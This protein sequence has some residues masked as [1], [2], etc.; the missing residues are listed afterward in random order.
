[1]DGA[2]TG[3]VTTGFDAAAV[4]EHAR[5]S[6]IVTDLSGVIADC[7]RQ[8]EVLYGR[9]RDELIGADAA[10]YVVDPLDRELTTA[11]AEELLTGETWSG[12][13]QVRRADGALVVVEAIASAIFDHG[14][15]FRGVVSV[16]LDITERRRAERHAS[17]ARV[18]L[19]VLA[20]VGQ[21]LAVELDLD[22]RLQSVA[23]VLLSD[24]ADLCAL[25]LLSPDGRLRLV[26]TAHVDPV[27]DD[28]FR[29]AADEPATPPPGSPIQRAIVGREPVLAHG[30]EAEQVCVALLA[31]ARPVEREILRCESAICLPLFGLDGRHGVLCLGRRAS[32]DPYTA[33]DVVAG[34]E[35][36]RRVDLAIDHAQRFE[37]QRNAAEVLQRSLLPARLPDVPFATI[38]WR[39]VPGSS[40][41]TI[42]GDWFDAIL[43]PD[44]RLVLAIGD[45]AGHGLRAAVAM[46]RARHCLEFCVFEGLSPGV[47]LER[48]SHFL[49]GT[50]EA[51]LVTAAVAILDARAG[52]LTLA[53][54]GHPPILVRDP[55]GTSSYVQ[56]V[57]GPPLAVIPEPSF[58]E[59]TIPLEQGATIVLYTDGLVERRG[60]AIT[61][62]FERLAA[63]MDDVPGGPGVADHLLRRLAS[64]DDTDDD[65]AVLVVTFDG[66]R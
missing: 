37:Q 59:T 48:M 9:P 64:A 20:R 35:L 7:N 49:Y 3:A 33:E 4:L 26:A 25:W 31:D 65:V 18:R 15:E 54:A 28:A 39:Y 16:A 13:F 23:R 11:I 41:L 50:L 22:E 57:N 47:M 46:G 10:Q 6:V 51:D 44:D 30:A 58:D 63:V 66:G 17:D 8:A 19:E 40:D 12:E 29:R 2:T 21:L 24:F 36:A 38:E 14:G 60:E 34:Q 43:L 53:S 55:G 5:V 32:A 42:G 1:L 45:V 61:E 62:G 27:G 52:T 56:I